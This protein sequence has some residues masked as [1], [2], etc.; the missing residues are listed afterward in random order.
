MLDRE[1]NV[2]KMDLTNLLQMY[3]AVLPTWANISEEFLHIC[4]SPE[5]KRGV[6]HSTSNT[7][8]IKVASG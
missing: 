2:I 1:I 5:D 4:A 6:Q 3:D 8:L 7:Y